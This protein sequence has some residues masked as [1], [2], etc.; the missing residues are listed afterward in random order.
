MVATTSAAPPAASS[1]SNRRVAT[2]AVIGWDAPAAARDDD[3]EEETE[4]EE[5][6][7]GNAAA[8][9]AP[10]KI[11]ADQFVIIRNMMDETEADEAKMLQ[12]VGAKSL[13]EMTVPQFDTAMSALRKK[14]S[15]SEAG[16]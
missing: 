4:E 14:K 10:K 13:E 6:E 7:F 9:A 8:A 12:F 3:E 15:Q 5:E 2:G 11:D 16:K 1:S